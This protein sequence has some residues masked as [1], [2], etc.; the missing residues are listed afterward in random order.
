MKINAQ[1]AIAMVIVEFHK[2][3]SLILEEITC[4]MP[5]NLHIL[6]KRQRIIIY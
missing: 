5:I 6:V 1:T 2:N 3:Y 4:K